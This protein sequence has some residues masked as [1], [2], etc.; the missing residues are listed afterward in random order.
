MELKQH[1]FSELMTNC[2]ILEHE[3]KSLII[4]P[5]I[6]ATEWVL[7]EAVNPVA[8]L[9]THGHFDH[10][11]SNLELQN[12]LKIPL[13]CPKEDVVLLDTENYGM[14]TPPSHPDI[15][16]DGDETLEM[17]PFTIRYRHFPGHTPGCSMIEIDD[18]IFSGDFIFRDS[19]GRSDFAYSDNTQM[20]RSLERFMELDFD[21]PLYPGHGESTTIAREQKNIPRWINVLKR[22]L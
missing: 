2:Y 4:D 15:T 3:G 20:V 16:P 14:Q 22:E 18:Y 7:K 6:G 17:A 5:G 13:V 8:I 1:A 12:T 9:N 21:K 19:I 11:W 10:V